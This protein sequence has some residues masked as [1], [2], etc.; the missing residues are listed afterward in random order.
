MIRC[1][2]RCRQA[3]VF[4][5]YIHPFSPTAIALGSSA[6]VYKGFGAELLSGSLWLSGPDPSWASRRFHQGSAKVPARV[7]QGSTK[8]LQ[9]SWCLWFSGADPCWAAKRFVE[10]SPITSLNLS[11]SSSTLFCIFLNSVSF[12]AFSHIKG[13]GAK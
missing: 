5:V 6:I 9:V 3:S 11:P 13:L 7:H 12:G 1:A 10:G 8:V 2:D 4:W